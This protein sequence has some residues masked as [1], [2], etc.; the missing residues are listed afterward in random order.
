MNSIHIL[1][2]DD[3]IS[4]LKPHI[5]FL[6]QKNYK[7][8]PCNSGSEAL[9]LF[10]EQDFDIVFLDENMPG[11]SGLETLTRTKKTKIQYPSSNDYQKVRKNILWKRLLVA[12]L[13]TT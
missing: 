6:E 12:K 13:L 1:W 5:I 3:E 11:L 4:Y 2:V 10:E 7:I 9:E 8:T